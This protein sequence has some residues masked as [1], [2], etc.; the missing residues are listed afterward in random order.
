MDSAYVTWARDPS[1]VNMRA[2][3]GK[4]NRTIDSALTSYAPNSAPAV[5]SKAKI[6][7]KKA[8]E[9]YDSSQSRLRTHIY[10]QLRPLGREANSYATLHVPERVSQDLSYLN[11]W[12]Q[13]FKEEKGHDPSDTDLADFSKL[14]K[15]RIAH[16]R[17]YDKNQ[18]FEGTIIGSGS[19]GDEDTGMGTEGLRIQ[20]AA[21]LW[22]DYVYE[23]LSKQDKLLYDLKMG[24]GSAIPRSVNEIAQRLK[25]TPSAVSQ[26]LKNIAKK[27]QEGAELGL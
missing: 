21:N 24:K 4:A 6:L 16:I 2:V 20:E 13:K 18:V 25:I 26:R 23:G 9:T 8:I 3:M 12:T 11:E 7:L 17:R 10:N 1:P 14:S 15:K 27:I 22:E 19:Q 5:R